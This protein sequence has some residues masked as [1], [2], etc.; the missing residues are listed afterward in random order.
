MFSAAV[1]TVASALIA[2]VG[3]SYVAAFAGKNIL[4]SYD[5]FPLV[6]VPSALGLFILSLWLG[7][8]LRPLLRLGLS[9][10]FVALV[11]AASPTHNCGD[12]SGSR[13]VG[14]CNAATGKL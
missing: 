13:A 6:F 9:M 14:N 12:T 1:L 2:I 5:G 10:V 3:A 4:Q 11:F 8:R 7:S